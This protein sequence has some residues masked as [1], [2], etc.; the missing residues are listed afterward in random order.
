MLENIV[1][2]KE[3]NTFDSVVRNNSFDRSTSSISNPF[4]SNNPVTDNANKFSLPNISSFANNVTQNSVNN[5]QSKIDTSG[6]AKEISGAISNAMSGA[7]LKVGKTGELIVEFR[8]ESRRL[9]E[10][11]SDDFIPFKSLG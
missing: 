9:K 10:L 6:M 2:N 5:I 7:V 8:K 3:V 1:T 11:G 4:F